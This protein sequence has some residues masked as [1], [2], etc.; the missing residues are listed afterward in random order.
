MSCG[1]IKKQIFLMFLVYS[2]T[3]RLASKVLFIQKH[4]IIEPNDI[5]S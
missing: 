1:I 2:R 5:F 3:K 4:H